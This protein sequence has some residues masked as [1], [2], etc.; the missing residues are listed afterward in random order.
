M[1]TFIELWKTADFVS[2]KA[3]R[4]ADRIKP[5]DEPERWVV[6]TSVVHSVRVDPESSETIVRLIGQGSFAGPEWCVN[7]AAE[8]ISA[9]LGTIEVDYDL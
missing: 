9:A 1:S 2:G 7:G 5:L 4:S 6:N 8:A 3:T